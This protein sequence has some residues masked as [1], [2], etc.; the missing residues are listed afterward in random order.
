M[1]LCLANAFKGALTS[2]EIVSL[3]VRAGVAALPVSDGGDGLLD[4]FSFSSPNSRLKKIRVQNAYGAAHRAEYLL[5]DKKTCVIESARVAPLGAGDIKNK[6]LPVL[7]TSSYGIGQVIC[8][9]YAAGARVFYIGLGGVAFNDGGAGMARALGVKF[10]GADGG[11]IAVNTGNLCE[12]KSLDATALKK[13]K[14]IKIYALTDVKN[15]LLGARGS[16]RVFGPQKGASRAEVEV[17]EAGLKN[18][19]SFFPRALRAQKGAAAAGALSYGLMAFLNAKAERGAE[20]IFKKLT[21]EKRI[22]AAE[23]LLLTEGKLDAQTFMGKAPGLGAAL[24]KKYKKETHFICGVSELTAA[25]AARKGIK[26]VHSF[27]PTPYTKKQ[28][29]TSIKN[30]KKLFAAKLSEIIT[31][32]RI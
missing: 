5:L 23:K 12:V 25:E 13:Y 15:P 16:A 32:H 21:V 19:S 14:G 28:I 26:K 11:E 3:C 6:K 2:K 27:L 7:K 22:A 10:L 20:F 4:A 1:I 30:S 8:S 18:L 31:P 9:A 17:I 29:K 24:A